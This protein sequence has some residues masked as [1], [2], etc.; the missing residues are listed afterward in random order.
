MRFPTIP[1]IRIFDET[2]AKEFYLKFLGMT[3]DWEH[4]F[5]EGGAGLYA[6][7]PR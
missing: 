4:R 5:G 3:L 2:K 1:I 7:F 6:G